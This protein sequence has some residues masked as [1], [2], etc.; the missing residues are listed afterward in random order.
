VVVEGVAVAAVTAAVVAQVAAVEV[1]RK[2]APKSTKLDHLNLQPLHHNHPLTTENPATP[3]STVEITAQVATTASVPPTTT[4][5]T[6]QT[7]LLTTAVEATAPAVKENLYDHSVLVTLGGNRRLAATTTTTAM[8]LP[9]QTAE[10]TTE[11]AMLLPSTEKPSVC[12]TPNTVTRTTVSYGANAVL[13]MVMVRVLMVVSAAHIVTA[14]TV[15]F[16]VSE[17]MML[18]AIMMMSLLVLVMVLQRRLYYE[19]HNSPVVSMTTKTAISTTVSSE[20]GK[21]QL[22][23]TTAMVMMAVMVLVVLVMMVLVRV[24]IPLKYSPPVNELML[25][26]EPRLFMTTKTTT[27]SSRAD[28]TVISAMVVMV[29]V[30]MVV[31]V[32]F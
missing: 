4:M 25:Q 3:A 8:P 26:G 29:L 10:L 16:G 32:G 1:V 9:A 11:S 20:A 13:V 23:A 28:A 5:T 18:V 30:V 21:R 7:T 19:I 27:V 15:S 12:M 2:T 31:M 17:S 24:S 6:R 22:R 14:T